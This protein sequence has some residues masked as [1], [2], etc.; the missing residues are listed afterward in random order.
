MYLPAYIAEELAPLDVSYLRNIV[1]VSEK[2]LR[3]D[4]GTVLRR[5]SKE[6]SSTV[7]RLTKKRVC[8][9]SLNSC[10]FLWKKTTR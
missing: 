4:S 2:T 3:D 8:G 9:D 10:V 5:W 1:A 6:C 7:T